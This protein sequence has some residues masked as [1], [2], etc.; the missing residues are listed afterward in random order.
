MHNLLHTDHLVYNWEGLIQLNIL[1]ALLSL[2]L[3]LGLRHNHSFYI[4]NYGFRIQKCLEL[5]CFDFIFF[6]ILKDLLIPEPF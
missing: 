5:R 3:G 2:N 4:F 6:L 1:S